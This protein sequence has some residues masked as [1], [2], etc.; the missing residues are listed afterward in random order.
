MMAA[1]LQSTQPISCL[2]QLQTQNLRRVSRNQPNLQAILK[3]ENSVVGEESPVELRLEFSSHESVVTSGGEMARIRA[4][5]A[6]VCRDGA[7][8]C[9]ILGNIVDA[10]EVARQIDVICRVGCSGSVEAKCLGVSE[11]IGVD[12][13]GLAW[14]Q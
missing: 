7:P 9:L 6:E 3:A 14:A 5:H 2:P 10:Q 13:L 4:K 12:I 8:S 1:Q 11:G